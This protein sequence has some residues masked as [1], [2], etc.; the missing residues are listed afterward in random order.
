VKE[1]E[2]QSASAYFTWN[3]TWT[4]CSACNTTFYWPVRCTP[5][6]CRLDRKS[7]FY[8]LIVKFFLN[9]VVFMFWHDIVYIELLYC[10]TN[11]ELVL[12]WNK[13]A[14]VENAK[15]CRL[16]PTFPLFQVI[17]PYFGLIIAFR[18]VCD[19]TIAPRIASTVAKKLCWRNCPDKCHY[20]SYYN[21]RNTSLVFF[22]LRQIIYFQNTSFGHWFSKYRIFTDLP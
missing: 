13:V 16:Y 5:R 20:W 2:R 3:I 11:F 22:K 7:T 18:F 6:S 15:M 12:T 1:V 17:C 4:L 14:V 21:L 8:K 9:G 19:V 10:V